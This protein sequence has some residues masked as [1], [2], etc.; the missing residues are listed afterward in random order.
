MSCKD[1]QSLLMDFLYDEI[2]DADRE[3]FLAHFARC[4]SCQ[5][6]YIAL[7]RTSG[8]LQEWED[9]DP[10]FNFI[11]VN[12]KRHWTDYLKDLLAKLLPQ[13]KIVT[14]GVIGSVVGI[15][16]LLAAA[17]TEISYQQQQ[18]RIRFGL[19]QKPISA[20]Q[21]DHL[22]TQRL[23]EQLQQENYLLM[24][25]LIQQSEAR[26]RKE[27]TSAMIQL[28]QDIERQRIEDLNLVGF[29]L[30]NIERNT[31]HRIQKTDNSLNEFIRLI[32][33]RSK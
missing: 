2:S 3:L 8:I 13:P 16:L 10:D 15:F 25:S 4:K 11:V 29:G 6:E 22:A 14:Y 30:E 17:N 20:E 18:F 7:K 21:T 12:E 19:F 26:Q 27:M 23:I 33:A 32:N 1:M 9:V 5:Q 31:Y 24:T 28:R